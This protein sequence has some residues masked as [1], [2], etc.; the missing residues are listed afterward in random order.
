MLASSVTCPSRSGLAPKPTQQLIDDSVT[1]T[2][3]STAS[4][5][6]PFLPNTSQAP[7]FAATPVS[8]VESTTGFPTT[9]APAC[10]SSTTAASAFLFIKTPS[11]PRNDDCKNFLR[12]DMFYLN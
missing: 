10:T 11:D 6:L 3:A 12:L 9:L 1:R 8:Q 4:S 5:A 2:P 7:L